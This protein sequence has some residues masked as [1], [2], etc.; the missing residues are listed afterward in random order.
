V[1]KDD[2]F[3]QLLQLAIREAERAL[4]HGRI[5]IGA[6]L[7]DHD[8]KV[9]GTGIPG[10]DE[11]DAF[12]IHAETEAIRAAGQLDDYARTT[13]VTT[14]TPCWYCAGLIRYLGIGAVIVGDTESWS[15]SGLTWL[16]SAG[17]TTKRLHDQVCVAMFEHWAGD[18]AGWADLPASVDGLPGP[19]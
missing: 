7:V 13:L 10:A 18:H 19:T 3:A 1:A 9:L 11:D 16:E 17:A 14:L 4:A 15:D 8:D 2:R 12:L 5:P 6:V